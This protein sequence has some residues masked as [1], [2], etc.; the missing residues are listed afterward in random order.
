MRRVPAVPRP[1]WQATVRAQGLVY[2]QTDLPDGSALPYWT[3]SA[4]YELTLAEVEALEEVTEELHAM[5]L[6]AARYA[7][8]NG[9]FADFDIPEWAAPAVAASLAAAPPSLYGRF[10]LRYD[11]TGPAQLL[12][13]NADTPT[14]L[15]EAAIVQW[16]WLRDAR[17]E[18]DQWNSLHERLVDGWRSARPRLAGDL[19]HFVWCDTEE[20][21]EDLLT[22]GYLAETAHQAGYGVRVLPIGQLGWSGTGFV[23]DVD[24]PVATCFKLYPWEWMLTE[25]YGALALDRHDPTVWIEPVWK[26][27]LSNKALLALLWELYPGH[28]NL[29]PATLSGPAGLPDAARTGWVAKPLLGREGAGIA[30]AAPGAPPPV[31]DPA[32]RYC[33]QQFAPLPSFAGN[34]VVLGSWVVPDATGVG[35]AAGAGF[36]ESDGLITDDR[37]R[38]LPHVVVD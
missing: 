9:R 2:A 17:P 20:T 1:Q 37:A 29:L 38:F 23:D 31:L 30:V 24:Q 32:Q 5:C 22:A 35:R 36:R 19:I 8:D 26:L 27:L 6:A 28:P 34:R 15:V 10:D 33:F 4:Y 12:E 11:G 14:A 13:Y 16:Y 21:G 3:E 25:P 18:C 7:V